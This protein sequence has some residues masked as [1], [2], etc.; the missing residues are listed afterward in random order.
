[1]AG[2]IEEFVEQLK[3][4]ANENHELFLGSI[5]ML[6]AAIDEKDP[7]TRG[8]SDR[9]AKYSVIVGQYLG[10][11]AE[12]L[13][14]IRISALLHDVGKIGV[15]DRVLKKPG[16]LTEE[17]F[18]LMKQHPSK[19]ANIMRPVAQL[20][21][22]LPGI[23]LHHEH[24]DGGGYPH[25]LQG[26]EIP[27]MARIIAAADTLDAMTTNRP[28]QSGMDLEFAMNRIRQLTGTKFDAAVVDALDRAVRAGKIRLT[29]KLVEAQV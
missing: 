5:R 13:D 20:K 17:E 11:R 7:Y 28:Y 9:V 14:K 21:E 10:L 15:D 16:K 25:G 29:A 22:M 27:L 2:D 1:M 6:A 18:S 26:D 12:E 24:V 19:G 4:A 8:H 23:E 3:Q